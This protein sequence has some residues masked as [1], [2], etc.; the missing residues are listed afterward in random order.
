MRILG[1][2]AVSGTDFKHS[3]YEKQSQVKGTKST[4]PIIATAEQYLAKHTHTHKLA[5]IHNRKS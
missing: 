2:L 3:V 4:L 5:T 1:S